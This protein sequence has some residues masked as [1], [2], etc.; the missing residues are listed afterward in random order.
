MNRREFT[1]A[2]GAK[3]T[4]FRKAAL[5]RHKQQVSPIPPA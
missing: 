3:G 5:H 2:L 4:V 1:A